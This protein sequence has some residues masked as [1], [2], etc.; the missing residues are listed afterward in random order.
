MTQ[1]QKPYHYKSTLIA[2][3]NLNQATAQLKTEQTN[4]IFTNIQIAPKLFNL[5]TEE[6]RFQRKKWNPETGTYRIT[7]ENVNQRGGSGQRFYLF[8]RLNTRVSSWE[9]ENY[10]GLKGMRREGKKT[11]AWTFV[12]LRKYPSDRLTSHF[13]SVPSLR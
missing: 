2:P 5:A 3:S 11:R 7:T 1:Y 4:I 13:F 6:T 10:S 9:M 8:I 12:K